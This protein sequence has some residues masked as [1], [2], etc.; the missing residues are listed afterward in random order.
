MSEAKGEKTLTSRTG[1]KELREKSEPKALANE[2]EK[3]FKKTLKKGLTKTRKCGIINKSLDEVTTSKNDK[4]CIL[5][6]EQCE[7]RKGK[8]K[9]EPLVNSDFRNKICIVL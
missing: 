6:T 9:L 5:K 1:V 8:K 4:D 3:K 2:S 7:K